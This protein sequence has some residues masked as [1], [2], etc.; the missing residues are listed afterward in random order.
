MCKSAKVQRTCAVHV[1]SMCKSAKV[2]RTV[3]LSPL[4]LIMQSDGGWH[5]RLSESFC[6]L[7]GGY[8]PVTEGAPV[9]FVIE[10]VG[11]VV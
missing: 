7:M 10:G 3:L 1:Q 5:K 4:R 2:Q 8:E 6:V 11:G 9:Q